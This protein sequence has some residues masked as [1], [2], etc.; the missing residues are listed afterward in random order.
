MCDIASKSSKPSQWH[1]SLAPNGLY[2]LLS[3]LCRMVKRLYT[4]ETLVSETGAHNRWM[5]FHLQLKD[6]RIGEEMP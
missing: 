4:L 1:S 3:L 6:D 5:R 2:H